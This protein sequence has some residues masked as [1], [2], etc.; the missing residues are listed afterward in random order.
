M[1]LITHGIPERITTELSQLNQ[2][3]AFVE[4]GTYLG[5]TTRW[6]ATQFEQVLTIER[7]E[8][9]YRQH[10]PGLA[11]IPNVTTHLGDSRT[12][13]PSIVADL[14]DCRAT[15]WLD[16]HYSG[17]E[18]AGE[19]DE[20][21]LLDELAALNTRNTDII[22]IDD[23]RLF[24]SAPPQPHQPSAWP[25]IA[26]IIRQLPETGANQ[27]VQVIDDVIFIVPDEE[28]LRRHL[29]RH[30]QAR[31][32]VAWRAWLRQQQDNQPSRHGLAGFFTRLRG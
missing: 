3:T 4:T 7:A 26:D 21:P 22:L 5:G 32:D 12:I 31:A 19:H 24:L 13:L 28:P 2:S 10:S 20:C 14:K 25:T 30:A 9:L 27:F 8:Q 15:F 11:A 6:A 1:G 23:A 29:I 16:G 17:G 18:T